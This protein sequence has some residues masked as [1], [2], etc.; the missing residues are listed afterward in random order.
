M[1]IDSQP[2]LE[3]TEDEEFVVFTLVV[4][5]VQNMELPWFGKV[6]P[7]DTY[8]FTP[9]TVNIHGIVD[10]RNDTLYAHVYHESEGKKAGNNVASLLMKQLNA[11]FWITNDFTNKHPYCKGELHVFF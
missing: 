4:D 2:F 8:Y 10:T 9:L 6:P 3:E 11:I 7:S 5:Y 1:I